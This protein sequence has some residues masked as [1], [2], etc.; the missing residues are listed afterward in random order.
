MKREI[1]RTLTGEG[2]SKIFGGF[3]EDMEIGKEYSLKFEFELQ[4]YS[5]LDKYKADSFE[6]TDINNFS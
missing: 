6:W 4:G 5:V 2:I 1:K 3:P